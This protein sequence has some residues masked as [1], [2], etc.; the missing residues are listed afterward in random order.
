MS[1]RKIPKFIK[2]I[3]PVA[4]IVGLVI[5]STPPREVQ[6]TEETFIASQSWEAPVNVFSVTAECWGGGA[7]GSADGNLAARPGG[8]GGGG[9]YAKTATVPV[10]PGQTY[11]ITVGAAVSAETNG[12]LSSFVGNDGTKC[13]AAGG[14]TTT[15]RS[16][17]AGGTVAASTGDLGSVFAGGAGGTAANSNDNGGA[18]GG[19]G[20]A[21]TA[22]GNNGSANSGGTGGA[23]GTGTDGGDGGPGGDNTADGT[24]G[25]A[26]GGGGGGAGGT[27]DVGGAG[28]KGRSKS[29]TPRKSPRP[30]LLFLMLPI[31]SKR[32]MSL[33]LPLT[34]M[35]ATAIKSKSRFA[36]PIL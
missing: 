23:G 15:N 6:A 21:T 16:G 1:I 20:A 22:T 10:T 12:N 13:E 32:E 3:L 26:P 19:E 14:T 34:G 36:R 18:G 8:G 30:S 27:N 28:Q 7:G 29:P 4:L 25:T 17:G 31:L 11:T 35:T 33:L 9:A 2:F 24:V 5:A